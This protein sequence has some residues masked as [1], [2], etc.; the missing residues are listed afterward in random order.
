MVSVDREILIIVKHYPLH[1]HSPDPG[2][3]CGV[4]GKFSWWPIVEAITGIDT[5][6]KVPAN[7]SGDYPLTLRAQ[8]LLPGGL[9]SY[10]QLSRSMHIQHTQ[11]LYN[12]RTTHAHCPRAVDISNR[13]PNLELSVSKPC[14][15][16]L[17][18]GSRPDRSCLVPPFAAALRLRS[19]LLFL[20][21]PRLLSLTSY[22]QETSPLRQQLPHRGFP[23]SHLRSAFI[24][25]TSSVISHSLELLLAAVVASDDLFPLFI[26]SAR[27][28]RGRLRQLV[29]RDFVI[30]RLALLAVRNR[31]CELRRRLGSGNQQ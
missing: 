17:E 6:A 3:S 26:A 4:C 31:G 9:L 28:L 14:G 24:N 1:R 27:G 23:P 12:G 10:V 16:M 22:A 7:A 13:L 21:G 8:S 2:H 30:D 18:D 20:P 15:A 11:L 5:E 25:V 19:F 29:G